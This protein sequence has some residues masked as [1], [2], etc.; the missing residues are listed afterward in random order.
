MYT[1]LGGS[2]CLR[3]SQILT[4]TVTMAMTLTL[5]IAMTKGGSLS[6]AKV[7]SAKPQMAFEL[8]KSILFA[9]TLITLPS[10]Q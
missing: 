1:K 8:I 4:F 3:I 10:S 7:S 6:R 9:Y 2:R 5:T